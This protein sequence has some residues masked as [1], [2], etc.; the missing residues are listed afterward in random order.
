MGFVSGSLGCRVRCKAIDV[1]VRVRLCLDAI[2][3]SL[4]PV[5]YARALLRLYLALHVTS[6]CGS[7]PPRH[8]E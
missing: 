1:I 5:F 3:P 6:V 7:L 4:C 8:R 2:S